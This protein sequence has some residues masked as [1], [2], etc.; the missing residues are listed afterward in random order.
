[1]TDQDGAAGSNRQW[2]MTIGLAGLVVVAL[3]VGFVAGYLTG[4]GRPRWGAATDLPVAAASGAMSSLA[5]NV[6]GHTTSANGVVTCVY[7]LPAKDQ[8]I[9]AGYT[10][11]CMEPNC[12]HTPVLACHC[13]TAHSMKGLTKQ[14]IVEGKSNKDIAAELT[15]RYGTGILPPSAPGSAPAAPPAPGEH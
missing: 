11:D 14:L 10:C 8:W 12:H 1:M 2:M 15:K 7:D 13:D 6:Q 9:L 5:A 3:G 4:G